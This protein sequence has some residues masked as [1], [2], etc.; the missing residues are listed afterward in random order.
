[1]S[2]NKRRERRRSSDRVSNASSVTPTPSLSGVSTSK[3]ASAGYKPGTVGA[4]KPIPVVAMDPK[5]SVLEA[6]CYMAS[7]R[8]DAVLIGSANGIAGIVTDKDLAFRVVAM[9]KDAKTTPCATIMTRDPV[10]VLASDAA[11]S[12]LNAMIAGQFRHLPVLDK[13]NV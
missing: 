1:M 10:K 4:L 3:H 8:V 12:A 13:D 9:A 6:A 11:T 5:V 7:R 2:N